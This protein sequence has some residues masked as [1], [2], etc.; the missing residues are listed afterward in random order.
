MSAENKFS[1][2]T[3]D[4]MVDISKSTIENNLSELYKIIDEINQ[5]R[6]AVARAHSDVLLSVRAPGW[7]DVAY[8][9]AVTPAPLCLLPGSDDC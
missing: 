1:E 7:R 6:V 3:N 5:M 4:P 9:V 8:L 2:Y